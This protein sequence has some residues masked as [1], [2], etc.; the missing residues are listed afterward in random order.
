MFGQWASSFT[1]AVST[2]IS[3]RGL[4]T[5]FNSTCILRMIIVSS[6]TSCCSDAWLQVR[7]WNG[8]SVDVRV[9][10]SSGGTLAQPLWYHCWHLP[11]QNIASSLPSTILRRHTPQLVFTRPDV[12][13]VLAVAATLGVELELSVSVPV[14]LVS[15]SCNGEAVAV[16]WEAG[17]FPGNFAPGIISTDVVST[18][19]T[20]R[21]LW[22]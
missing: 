2:A 16:L 6:A 8:A 7:Q 3:S 5:I 21:N 17:F 4:G 15:L 11:S 12:R 14:P 9:V 20:N 19:P 13:L 1:V 22:S 18:E 10:N